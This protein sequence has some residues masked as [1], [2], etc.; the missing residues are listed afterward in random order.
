MSKDAFYEGLEIRYKHLTGHV[1]FVCDEY[2][3]LCIHTNENPLKD[4]CVLI[5]NNQWKD[6]EL[7]SGNRQIHDK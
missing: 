7:M 3:T 1:K 2:I 5:F 6:I 4:V